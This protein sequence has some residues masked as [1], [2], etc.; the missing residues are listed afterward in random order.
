M[1]KTGTANRIKAK[2]RR[3]IIRAV[4]AVALAIYLVLALNVTAGVSA[5]RK[6]TGIRIAVNDTASLKFVTA[7][8]LAR[9]LGT[10]PADARGMRILDIDTDSIE[11]FL[12]AIDKIEKVNA[13]RLTDGAV[14]VTVDP[15]HPVARVFDGDKSYYINRTG[16]RISANARYHIDVPVIQGHFTDSLFPPEKVVPLLDY[17]TADSLWNSL[18]SMVKVDRANDIILVPI[19]RGQVINFGSPDNFKNKFNRLERMYAEVMPVKGWSYYDTISVKW[20]GQIVATRRHKKL[21]QPK[22]IEED[23]DEDTDIGAM[24]VGNGIAPGQVK[25]GIEAKNDK[26]IPAA[27]VEN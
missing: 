22:F 6:C 7:T 5:E 10:L 25:A 26:P 15:L 23:D 9:E 18:V 1:K 21:E 27:K 3:T 12:G 4:V 13:I 14:L 8:E 24:M 20:N 17:I 2:K 19:V 16:K 11:R